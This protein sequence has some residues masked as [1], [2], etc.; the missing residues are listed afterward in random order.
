MSS[1]YALLVG[2]NDYQSPHNKL[3]GCV[4]DIKKVENYLHSSLSDIFS[5]EI[6]KLLNEEATY[7][8]VLDRFENH[9]GQAKPNDV[10]WFHFS[11]HGTELASAPE[12]RKSPTTALDQCLICYDSG[13]EK[14]YNI[15][16]KEMAALINKVATHYPN[17]EIKEKPPHIL[18]TLDCCHSGSGTRS[19]K[20][21]QVRSSNAASK[22][23]TLDSY[24]KGYYTNKNDLTI[25]MSPHIAIS[26]CRHFEVAGDTKGGGAFTSGLLKALKDS[27]GRLT[28]TDLYLRT[29]SAVRKMRSFQN[30]KFSFISDVSPYSYFLSNENINERSSF[31]VFY[32]NGK[33][34]IKYGAIHGLS[35]DLSESI[36][37]EIYK[38][39]RIR[40]KVGNAKILSVGG[41][42]KLD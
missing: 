13:P 23:R 21:S 22:K 40:Q 38:V 5:L 36:K 18:I 28:Y 12:F 35:A 10:I 16:D 17:G 37:I 2:I 25:P 26:A 32:K 6:E 33:W 19:G 11:G 1:L 30:P 4:K 27:R 39:G 7:E 8:N 42:G 15:A 3:L 24:A 29:R 31:E 41:Y 34:K 9:L 14:S 20:I